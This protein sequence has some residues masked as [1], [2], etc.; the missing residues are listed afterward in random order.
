M[1]IELDLVLPGLG[2][3]NAS[4]EQVAKMLQQLLKLK[5]LPQNLDATDGLAASISLL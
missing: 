4:K 3:G 5:S 2:S 1:P